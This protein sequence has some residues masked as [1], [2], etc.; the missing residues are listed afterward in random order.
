M[1][2]LPPHA[3]PVP[4]DGRLAGSEAA[5]RLGVARQTVNRWCR[6]HPGLGVRWDGR[7]WLDLDALR[8]FVAKRRGGGRAEA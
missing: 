3:P 8:A 2:A 1:D 4:L 6:K 7:W 5:A